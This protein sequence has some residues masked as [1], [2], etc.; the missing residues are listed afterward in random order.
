LTGAVG[1]WTAAGI[2]K[3]RADSGHGHCLAKH[4]SS[5]NMST[6]YKERSR[7]VSVLKLM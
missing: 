5:S 1:D 7:T 4:N 2:R 6:V 3:L